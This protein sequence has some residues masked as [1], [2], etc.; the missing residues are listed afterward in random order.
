MHSKDY[1]SV[2][3]HHNGD[4]SG[5]YALVEI[6]RG[7]D[8]K[9]IIPEEHKDKGLY[10]FEFPEVE[11][12]VDKIEV[13]AEQLIKNGFNKEESHDLKIFDKDQKYILVNSRDIVEFYL[14]KKRMEEMTSL[15]QMTF[16]EL[17]KRYTTC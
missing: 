12:E 7:V 10:D 16:E 2:T 15:E 13:L 4:Y 9:I 17:L 6:R 3:I 14:E 11:I 1:K 8:G 5:E